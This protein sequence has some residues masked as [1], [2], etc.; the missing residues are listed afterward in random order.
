[1]VTVL[2]ESERK[3]CSIIFDTPEVWKINYH[4]TNRRHYQQCMLGLAEE[5]RG[6]PSLLA[7][8]V[9]AFKKSALNVRANRVTAD[10][11][12]IAEQTRTKH[13]KHT[14]LIA[15]LAG[16]HNELNGKWNFSEGRSKV[17]D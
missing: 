1:M 4:L 12:E 16:D 13:A 14:A 10:I 2:C 15:Q 9:K 5:A 8:F 11:E 3:N 17:A 7:V 6:S